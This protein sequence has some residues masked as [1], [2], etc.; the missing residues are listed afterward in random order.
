[1]IIPPA[2]TAAGSDNLRLNSILPEFKFLSSHLFGGLLPSM[3]VNP[4]MGRVYKP[5]T[6]GGIPFGED[7]AAI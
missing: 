3:P 6:E 7:D 5:V 2:A 1:M 4:G